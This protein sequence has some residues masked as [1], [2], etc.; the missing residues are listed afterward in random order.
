MIL[1]TGSR[2]MVLRARRGMV[3]I[4]LANKAYMKFVIDTWCVAGR[5]S[6]L[7]THGILI[8]SLLSSEEGSPR[9]LESW[10]AET[11]PETR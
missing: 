10:K 9:Y 4:G 5:K 2:A 7:F 6:P 3:I 8:K 11:A 1:G